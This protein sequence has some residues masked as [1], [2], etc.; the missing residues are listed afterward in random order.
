M[1]SALPVLPLVAST[2][3]SPGLSRPC[4]SAFSTMYQAMRALIEPEGFM[5]SSLANTPS[6]S[7]S[8]V[9]PM[10]SRI[11]REMRSEEHTSEL[12][13]LMRI[14]YAVFCLKKKK[15]EKT[16]QNQID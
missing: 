3:V 7:S 13:S 15:K 8:G 9:S 11:E 4:C 6:I 10:A 5:N 12:Q 14:S 1:D 16:T 2:I